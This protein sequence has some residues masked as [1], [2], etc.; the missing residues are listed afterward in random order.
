MTKSTRN[1]NYE[2]VLTELAALENLR[3]KF[4]ND[5][6]TTEEID[7]SI[8]DVLRLIQEFQLNQDEVE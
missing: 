4:H 1:L 6:K 5:K 3:E 7:K 8:E 2:D